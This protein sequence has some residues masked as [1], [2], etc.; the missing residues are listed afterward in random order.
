MARVV[1][2]GTPNFAL[3]ILAA[4]H[5]QHQVVA[6][7]TQP[8]QPGGRGR[9]ERIVSP[10][11]S[12][13]ETHGL[14][15]LQPERLRRDKQ[16]ITT[17]RHL[18]P[19]VLVLAAYGQILRQEVLSIAPYGCIGVHASLLPRLRG[20]A[21]I[22]TA[23]LNGDMETGIS[24]MLTDA[25]MD[26]GPIIARRVVAIAPEQTT[27]S[28]TEKLA[29]CGAVTIL[30][31]LPRWLAGEI[32]AEPQDDALATLAPP[33]TKEQGSLDWSLP[34][35]VLDRHVRALNPWPGTFTHYAGMIL[36]VLE[37]IPVM[38]EWPVLNVGCVVNIP[39]GIGVT[40][41]QGILLLR[42]IQQAGKRAMS[43]QEYTRGH[44][45]FCNA[46]LG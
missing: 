37:T 25:G 15:V 29:S 8:D 30:E 42:H 11:K 10:V 23:I 3:P 4:L 21:P 44:R 13:A 41:G 33:L 32:T 12:W 36:K 22:A 9:L 18:K 38:V 1:F 35:V 43:A 6:V 19:D 5:T 14:V 7:I 45:D 20:A 24:L 27:T 17:I 2:L 34:A 40:T 26:T 46:H 16:A 31:V 28:L 39:E